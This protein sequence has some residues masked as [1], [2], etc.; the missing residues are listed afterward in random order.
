MP[1]DFC[2]EGL[3][4]TTL[5]DWGIET[6]ERLITHL[7]ATPLDTMHEGWPA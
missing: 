2:G 6:T 4:L 3:R 1:D 5:D 7:P